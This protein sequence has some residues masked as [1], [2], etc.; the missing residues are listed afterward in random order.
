LDCD[1]I[2]LVEQK[3]EIDRL[4]SELASV[5]ATL[6]KLQ[7]EAFNLGYIHAVNNP[8]AGG[9]VRASD[10]DVV[11]REALRRYPYGEK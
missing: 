8:P 7:R 4:K 10:V 9:C 3:R 11:E 6:P 1:A 2:V 5:R